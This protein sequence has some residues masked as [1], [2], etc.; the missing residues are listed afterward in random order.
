MTVTLVPHFASVLG[1]VALF[2]GRSKPAPLA[3]GITEHQQSAKQHKGPQKQ[4]GEQKQKRG[5]KPKPA[6]KAKGPA[7]E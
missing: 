7:G 3:N 5:Q 1:T 6:D 4:K 2:E